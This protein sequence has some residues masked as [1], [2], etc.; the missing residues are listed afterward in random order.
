MR[1][2]C[3]DGR[4]PA[5]SVW[6]RTLPR[7]SRE[8]LHASDE[9][10]RSAEAV[11]VGAGLVGLCSAFSL[12][13][14]GV[15]DI[16]IVE[17]GVICGESTGA[18]AGGIWLA[19]EHLNRGIDAAHALRGRELFARLDKEFDFDY[20]RNGLLAAAE[21]IG[22]AEARKAAER[23]RAAGLEAEWIS[24]SA[25]QEVEPRLDYRGG[26]FFFPGDGSIHPLK[27]AVALARY[28]RGRGTRICLGTEVTSIEKGLVKTNRGAVAAPTIIVTAGAW[29]PLL[30][31]LLGWEPPIRP[32]RGTLLAWPAQPAKTLRAVVFGRRF[33]YWQLPCGTVAGGGSEDDIGFQT[34]VDEVATAEIESEFRALFPSLAGVTAAYGW[35]GFRPFCADRNPVVGAVPGSEGVYVAAGHFRRGIQLG[36]LTGELLAEEIVSGRPPAAS[37]AF[38]PERFSRAPRS[39]GQQGGRVGPP[40][41][42]KPRGRPMP[43]P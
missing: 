18:S 19:H 8:A 16:V 5:D 10:P 25:V 2:T 29:T 24:G 7:E 9:L 20:A 17:R 4:L 3:Y 43:R 1:G 39:S 34:G 32:I 41:A 27:L 14:R 31:R 22:A 33:Y 40:L 23:T 6:F 11:V 35:S 28:L 26:A 13:R 15:N 36:P 21:S 12:A 38:R 30:T 37:A 42:G